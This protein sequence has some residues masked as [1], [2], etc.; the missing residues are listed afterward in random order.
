MNRLGA[1][2][3]GSARRGCPAATRLRAVALALLAVGLAA[4]A[5][6]ASQIVSTSSVTHLALGVNAKGEA[7]LTYDSRGKT[8]HVLAW[9]AENA[10][11][12]PLAPESGSAFQ[13]AYDGGY[14][15]EFSR[16]PAAQAALERLRSLQAQMSRA[17]AAD[18]SATR[19]ALSPQITAAYAALAAVRA[20]ATDYWRTFT[21]PAYSGPSPRGV[22]LACTA[23]DGSHWALESRTLLDARTSAAAVLSGIQLAHWVG[24]HRAAASSRP[25]KEGTVRDVTLGVNGKGEAMVGYRAGGK[26]IHVLASSGGSSDPAA[27]P[28]SFRLAYDGGYTKYF[29]ENPAATAALARLRSLQD[30]MSRA[31]AAGDNP[32]RWALKPQIAAAYAAVARLRERATDYWRTFTCPAYTG[33]ALASLVTACTAPDG[34]FWAVQSW[35]RDLP[36]YG[37]APTAAQSQLEVHLSH[38]TGPIAS[39]SVHADWAYGG[40]WNHLWGAFTYAGAG[41]YGTASTAVGVPLDSFGRNVYVDTLDSAYGPG[42]RREN[43]FLTHRPGGTW[44]YSVNPHGSHPAGTGSA[45]R[46]TVLGPGVTPDVSVT[47]PAPGPFDREAQSRVDAELAT[48]HDPRCV[49]HNGSG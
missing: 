32:T 4:P 17:T 33:P 11:P 16:N 26:T 1:I 47:V 3:A 13:L 43:S 40:Q 5:S 12:S 14:A 8:V 37:L 49:P 39:L 2:A 15:K 48:L 9:G 31:A 42:W 36:D 10:I 20:Q 41:V 44:C 34:S 29:R 30:R 23:P 35:D 6:Q 27:D 19:S 45:Y 24:D 21:C 7:M 38:W 46:L 22:A 28:G 25:I 18:D